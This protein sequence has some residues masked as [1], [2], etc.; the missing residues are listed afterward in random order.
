MVGSGEG[1]DE[2][3]STLVGANNLQ[4]E[5]KKTN[6]KENLLLYLAQ[7]WLETDRYSVSHQNVGIHDGD[8]LMQEVRLELKQL[9]R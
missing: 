1:D 6:V 3:S 5:K 2:L 8:E 9:W 4:K 7:S